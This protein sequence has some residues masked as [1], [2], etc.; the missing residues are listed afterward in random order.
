MTVPEPV[1]IIAPV[2]DSTESYAGVEYGLV[3]EVDSNE[4]YVEVGAEA[5]VVWRNSEGD[6]ISSDAR[7]TVSETERVTGGGGFRSTLTFSPLSLSD[8]GDYVCGVVITPD[9]SWPFVSASNPRE[10]THTLNVTGKPEH[11]H[12]HTHQNYS[13][14]AFI[15]L[16]PPLPILMVSVNGSGVAG[17]VLDIECVSQFIQDLII[18]P[19]VMILDNRGTNVEERFVEQLEE[20]VVRVSVLLDP[21]LTSHG[22]VFICISTYNITEAG[23]SNAALYSTTQSLTIN[24]SSKIVIR[25]T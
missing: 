15:Y 17:E 12:T 23:L 8:T 4:A 3:C 24:V 14:N 2:N 5:V 18:P 25:V 19:S 16:V 9:S 13:F 7:I 21:L 11:T 1:V 10:D 22:G 6:L 20:G